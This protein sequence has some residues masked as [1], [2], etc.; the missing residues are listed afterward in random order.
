[1]KKM[2][3]IV[4]FSVVITLILSVA[5]CGND[6]SRS[7]A[8]KKLEKAISPLYIE[9]IHCE[10]NLRSCSALEREIGESDLFRLEEMNLIKVTGQASHPAFIGFKLM[11]SASPYTVQ[12]KRYGA[13]I[14]AFI[15]GTIDSVKVNGISKPA[16]SNGQKICTV[17][18]SATYKATPFGEV[19]FKNNNE[20]VKSG[21]AIFVLYDDGWRIAE[22]N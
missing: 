12:M 18:Y 11:D 1:M 16:D 8:A 17:S 5:S 15:G 3:P 21:N 13:N 14:I 20:L 22:I 6:I 2:F 10:S 4:C 7:D 9:S 19:L